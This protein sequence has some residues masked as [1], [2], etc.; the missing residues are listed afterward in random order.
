MSSLNNEFDMTE[1]EAVSVI[2][3]IDEHIEQ[4]AAEKF[5]I[6]CVELYNGEKIICMYDGEE[7]DI[8]Y[9]PVHLVENVDSDEYSYRLTYV[10]YSYNN[11]A[12]D[13]SELILSE[14]PKVMFVP[15]TRLLMR[16]ME[17]WN[18]I[19]Q[20]YIQAINIANE[21]TN[22]SESDSP[23]VQYILPETLTIS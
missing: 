3:Y 17:Y 9:M 6:V 10:M 12:S 15:K 23:N 20:A 16:Y 14:P 11:L 1:Q 8:L 18:D 2:E 5:D 7:P 22:P 13:C 19:K 4:Y 21:A